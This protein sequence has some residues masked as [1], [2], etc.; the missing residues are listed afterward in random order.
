MDVCRQRN[1]SVWLLNRVLFATHATD[2]YLRNMSY[3]AKKERGRACGSF[4][5]IICSND[6]KTGERRH[7]SED[8][9]PVRG[10]TAARVPAAPLQASGGKHTS[11]LCSNNR[12]EC[13]LKEHIGCPLSVARLDKEGKV[14]VT[15][16]MQETQYRSLHQDQ[17]NGYC[18]TV[19]V[20]DKHS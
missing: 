19:R 6:L 2:G 16:G 3:W 4:R 5:G 11:H 17:R 13:H 1:Y 12:P 8:G 14:R 10:K 18:N 7:T 9:P 20:P 15:L